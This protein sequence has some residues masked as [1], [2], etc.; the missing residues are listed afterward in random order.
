MK[1]TRS[2]KLYWTGVA[3]ADAATSLRIVKPGVITSIQWMQSFQAGAS[4]SGCF[5]A[6]LSKQSVKSIVTNDTPPGV[7]SETCAAIGKGVSGGS[8]DHANNIIGLANQV[9]VGDTLYIHQVLV[10]TA[11]AAQNSSC[12]VTVLEN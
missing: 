1:S 5:Q 6:E 2:Y 3:S 4:Q 10:G 7:I 8:S 12:I 9:D 11:P